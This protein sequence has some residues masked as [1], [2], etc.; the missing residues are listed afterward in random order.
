MIK[1]FLKPVAPVEDFTGK[2][3]GRNAALTKEEVYKARDLYRN[4]LKIATLAKTYN[5]SQQT[6]YNALAGRGVYENI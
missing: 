3:T 1:K 2:S 6:M 4:G 5:V